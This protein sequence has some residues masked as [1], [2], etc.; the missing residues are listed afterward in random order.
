[1]PVL[2]QASHPPRR[3][4]SLA[5]RMLFR[6]FY[7][8]LYLLL[9]TLFFGAMIHYIATRQFVAIAALVVPTLAVLFGFTAL[10]YNRA[11]A[12]PAGAEQRR[13]LY[14][15]ERGMQ[16]AILF[17]VAL[18]V[19]LVV[20]VSQHLQMQ[21]GTISKSKPQVVETLLWFS[22]AVILVLLSFASFFLAFRAVSHRLI[23]YDRG[24]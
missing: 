16:A 13:S 19:G 5:G 18:G 7:Y 9:A 10:L 17:L 11:R 6:A 24:G 14:A 23:G 15:A 8:A 1:M 12:F 2:R 22:P 20:G 3:Y 21:A 4:I